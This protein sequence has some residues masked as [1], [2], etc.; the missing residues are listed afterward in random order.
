MMTSIRSILLAGSCCKTS[1]RVRAFI[2]VD[3]LPFI[4]IC[5]FSFPL[6]LTFPSTSTCTDGI[7]CIRSLADPE[8]LIKSCPTLNVFLSILCM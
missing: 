6:R 4:R 3:G 1:A 7:F 5:T 8:E 2:R